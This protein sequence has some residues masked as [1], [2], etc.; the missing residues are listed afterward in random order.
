MFTVGTRLVDV[1]NVGSEMSLLSTTRFKVSLS[2]LVV[3]LKAGACEA[4]GRRDDGPKEAGVVA[5]DAFTRGDDGS[6]I[7]PFRG[8]TGEG[9]PDESYP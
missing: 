1:I 9:C 5:G 4:E 8:D 6:P 3:V 2:V 7:E